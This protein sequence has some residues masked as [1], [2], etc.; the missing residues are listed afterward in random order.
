MLKAK[1]SSGWNQLSNSAVNCGLGADRLTEAA[2][3]AEEHADDIRRA[4]LSHFS[5]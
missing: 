5:G 4:W 1:R 2:Q 3:L